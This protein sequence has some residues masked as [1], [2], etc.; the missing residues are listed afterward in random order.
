MWVL[1]ST[2][3]GSDVSAFRLPIRHETGANQVLLSPDGRLL[4]TAGFDYQLRLLGAD[5][6]QLAAPLLHH[7]ALVEALAFSADGRFLASADAKGLVRVW[8]LQPRGVIALPG[9]AAKPTPRFTPGGKLLV[10]RDLSDRLR[11]WDTRT[12]APVGEALH[13]PESTA[14][15]ADRKSTRLNSSHT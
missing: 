9:L 15:P 12:S 6:H 5:R 2:E 1:P 8:D 10:G 7:T 13:E 3:A 14:D 4:A 11:V